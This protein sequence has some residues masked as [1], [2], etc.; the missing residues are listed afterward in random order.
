MGW[1]GV[2]GVWRRREWD[3]KGGGFFCEEE[4][5]AGKRMKVLECIHGNRRR[6]SNLRVPNKSVGLHKRQITAERKYF[7]L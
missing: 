4:K 3:S 7:G 6:P 5:H 2:W 1:K